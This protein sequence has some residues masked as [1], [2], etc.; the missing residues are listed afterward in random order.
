MVGDACDTALDEALVLGLGVVLVLALGRHHEVGG[1]GLGIMHGCASGSAC[2]GT[3][4]VLGS[5]GWGQVRDVGLTRGTKTRG[6]VSGRCSF[7]RV[8]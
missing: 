8:G 5:A 3:E 1:T 4:P 7:V 2:R 6:K